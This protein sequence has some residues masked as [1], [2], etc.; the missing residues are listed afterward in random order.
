MF[1]SAATPFFAWLLVVSVA[2]LLSQRISNYMILFGAAYCLGIAW[3][4][5]GP[6]SFGASLLGAIVGFAVFIWPY[7]KGLI[8]AGDVKLIG[9][10]GLFMGPILTL[11]SILYASVIGGIC[12]A[13]YLISK[14]LLH[15]TVGNVM[16]LGIGGARI[17][18]AFAIS[19]GALWAFLNPNFL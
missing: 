13:L 8:G 4:S 9:V 6:I 1:I 3:F 12:A 10:V 2:D 17:P 18:Y 5:V 11:S 7:A 19:L 14:G 16:R 15:K